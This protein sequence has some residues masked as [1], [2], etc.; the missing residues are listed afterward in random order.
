MVLFAIL[1]PCRAAACDKG[2]VF[3]RL[4][5]LKELVGFFM[6]GKVGAGGGIVHLVE[7]EAAQRSGD[8]AHGVF[9]FG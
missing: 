4:Y 9:V 7:A 2:Q 5:A 1:Y 3:A 8:A 6:H